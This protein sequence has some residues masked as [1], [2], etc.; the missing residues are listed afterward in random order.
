MAASG[1]GAAP[2]TDGDDKSGEA[3]KFTYSMWITSS[4]D[5]LPTIRTKMWECSNTKGASWP[6]PPHITL[7]SGLEAKEEEVEAKMR[8][9]CRD[10]NTAFE[11]TFPEVKEG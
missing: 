4:E 6:F 2:M 11:V 10:I 5:P 8:A 9:V 7:A 3:K 1:S